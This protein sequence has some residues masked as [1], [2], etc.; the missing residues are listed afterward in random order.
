MSFSFGVVCV[1]VCLV[2]VCFCLFGSLLKISVFCMQ[3]V[4]GQMSLERARYELQKW[5]SLLLLVSVGLD[6]RH[7]FR[8][9]RL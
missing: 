7:V 9:C 2:W 6:G 4:L 1:L 8:L 5:W 3:P